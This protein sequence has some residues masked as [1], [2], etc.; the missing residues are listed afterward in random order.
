MPVDMLITAGASTYSPWHRLDP[1]RKTLKTRVFTSPNG[2]VTA[3]QVIVEEMVAGLPTSPGPLQGNPGLQ[4]LNTG[5]GVINQIGT[6]DATK[7]DSLVVDYPVDWLRVRTDANIAGG[8]ISA[9]LLEG[10]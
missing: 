7:V 10:E 6:L 8:T 4:T 2:V 9:R 5:S 1:G 3:G